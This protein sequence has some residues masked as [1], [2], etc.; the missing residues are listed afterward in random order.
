MK[1]KTFDCVEMKRRA[2][3]RIVRQT[4]DLTFAEKVAYWRRRSEAFQAEQ[5]RLI[6]ESKSKNK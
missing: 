2:A 3:E 6:Q 1:T 4:K 5:D